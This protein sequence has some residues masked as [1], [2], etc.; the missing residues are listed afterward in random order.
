M[1]LKKDSQR[2][3]KST[4]VNDKE[5]EGFTAEERAAMK[6]RSKELKAE[7]RAKKKKADGESD[8]LAKIAEMPEPDRVMAERLHAII[9]ANAPALSPKTWYGMPA[10]AQ[11]GK[12]VCFFQSAQKFNTRYATLG[13]SDTATL[14]DGDMWPVAFALKALTA[15]EEARIIELVKKAAS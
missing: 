2:S 8:V 5:S 6:E 13:F 12:V 7:A 4:I 14:D 15:A 11:D 1:S 3:A 9:K 10:Y